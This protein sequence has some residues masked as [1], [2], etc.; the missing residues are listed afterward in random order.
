MQCIMEHDS[1]LADC[2]SLKPDSKGGK[3]QIFPTAAYYLVDSV[4]GKVRCAPEVL[5]VAC[6]YLFC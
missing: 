4:K 6:K 5:Y 3:T 1:C 2:Y